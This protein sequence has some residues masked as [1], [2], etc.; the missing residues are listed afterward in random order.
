MLCPHDIAIPLSPDLAL[1]TAAPARSRT[2]PASA[3]EKSPPQ[4]PHHLPELRAPPRCPAHSGGPRSPSGRMTI[5]PP[6]FAVGKPLREHGG[7]VSNTAQ[8]LTG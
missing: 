7:V 1:A 2:A 5:S 4:S 6:S 3:P 8:V